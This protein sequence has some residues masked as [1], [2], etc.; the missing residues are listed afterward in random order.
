MAVEGSLDRFDLPEVL[1]LVSHQRK[2]G[3]LT[4]QGDRNIVAVS[5]LRGEVVA[6][7]AL[8]QTVE[9]GLGMVL[10]RRGLLTQPEFE[11]VASRHH[12]GAGR[13]IDLLVADGFLSR[14]DLLA[15]LREQIHELL[16]ELLGWQEGEFKF[17][18]GDE[19]S[20]EEGFAPIP[21]EELLIRRLELRGATGIPADGEVFVRVDEPPV[22]IRDRLGEPR[23]DDTSDGVLWLS[24]EERGLY[25]HLDGAETVRSLA[26][27]SGLDTFKVRCALFRLLRAGVIVAHQPAEGDDQEATEPA[28]VPPLEVRRER[29][30]PVAAPAPAVSAA[31]APA[32]V[33]PAGPVATVEYDEAAAEH[34]AAISLSRLES[35]VAVGLAATVAA[36]LAVFTA[37]VPQS[38]P[39][40]LPW[41]GDQRQQILDTRWQAQSLAIDRAA[42]TYFLLAGRFPEDLGALVDLR[43]LAPSDLIDPAGRR[44]VYT[45]GPESY[46]LRLPG[47]GAGGGAAPETTE[48]ITGNFLLD[49]DFLAPPEDVHQAPL[50]LLD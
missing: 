47:P 4:V 27:T 30:R 15:A 45:P 9:E 46:S 2:T 36:A 34:R 44:L 24:P 8:N 21:I 20:F 32:A 39:L 48:A 37:V 40:P 49:P 42:K 31:A 17:Y 38:L 3:I 43:L 7:D 29:A 18:A 22:E 14:D 33:Q 23:P 16:V 1:Q 11:A 35:W 26:T 25:E 19:V 10:V 12:A 50:V 5:F 13:L 28:L 6:A 41:H